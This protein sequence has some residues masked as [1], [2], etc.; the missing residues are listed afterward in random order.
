MTKLLSL[1]VL[2]VLFVPGD[3][4]AAKPAADKK[5][6]KD[7]LQGTWVVT[8][9][10]LNGE[11][12]PAATDNKLT[13]TFK[14]DTVVA[15]EHPDEKGTFK[16]DQEKKPP[17]LEI[18]FAAGD[19]ARTQLAIYELKD[20]TL[21]ICLAKKDG[22]EFPTD[23]TSKEGNML[24]TLKR[25]KAEEVRPKS[26]AEKKIDEVRQRIEQEKQK[27]DLA[28]MKVLTQ[29]C[30]AYKLKNDAWPPDLETLAKA[31]GGAAYIEV[32]ALK[33]K[34]G[35]PFKYD[36]KGPKNNGLKPDIWVEVGDVKIGNW[37]KDLPAGEKKPEK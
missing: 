11:K 7:L 31:D 19:A 28:Q 5:A 1:T 22:K 14:G 29:A 8:A 9:A 34:T 21:K 35:G 15:S 6:D 17:T 33:S 26:E 3:E 25:E 27:A 20:D 13:V 24:L 16:L 36:P 2:A 12:V 30:E 37:M 4:P 18:K 10:E 23:F 32:A